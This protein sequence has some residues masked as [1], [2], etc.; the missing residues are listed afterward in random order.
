M[1]HTLPEKVICQIIQR[2]PHNRGWAQLGDD[3]K[4]FSDET[5]L[6]THLIL[7]LSMNFYQRRSLRCR[8]IRCIISLVHE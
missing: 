7:L 2:R 8:Y 3:L 4:R 5:D 6:R 1:F